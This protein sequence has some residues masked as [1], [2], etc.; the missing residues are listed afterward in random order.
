MIY[1]LGHRPSYEEGLTKSEAAGKPFKKVGRKEDYQ[2][3]SVWR[4]REGV[5][6]YLKANA[7]RLH[8]YAVYGVE[9]D[10]ERDTAPNPEHPFHDLLVDAPLVRLEQPRRKKV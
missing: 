8:D 4:T 3:G 5:E 6:A 2:G 9:A 1:T 7:H 10:W